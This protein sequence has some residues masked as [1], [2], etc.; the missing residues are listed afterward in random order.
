[1]LLTSKFL[2]QFSTIR[3]DSQPKL[4]ASYPNKVHQEMEKKMTEFYELYIIV[5]HQVMTA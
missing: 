2:F 5:E 1:M 3:R 4:C